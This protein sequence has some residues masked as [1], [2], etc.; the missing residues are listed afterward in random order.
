MALGINTNVASLSAQN[1]LTKSQDMNSQALERL[2]SGLRI[3][4]AKDDAAGLAISTR[5]SSQISGL[6]VAGRNAN[7]AISLAQ[8][9]EGAL[10]EITNN[11]QRIRELAV[12]SANSTNSSSDRDALNQ[13]VQQRVEEVNRIAGQTSFNG[14][15][16]LNG[17][18]GQAE[19]QVGANVGE[20]IGLDLSNSV[21]SSSIG[22][23]AE[24]E[25]VDLGTVFAEA[26][27]ATAGTY[28]TGEI[29]NFDFSDTAAA[30]AVTF[31]DSILDA[32]LAS[33]P[34]T[35]KID[36]GDD[37]TL[38]GGDLAANVAIL[39]G[40]TGYSAAES[41][42]TI[43]LTSDNSAAAPAITGDS[44][45][46]QTP[47]PG[48]VGET[49]F[50]VDGNTVTL[51]TDTS[52]LAG[53]ATEIGTQLGA[54]YAV[55]ASST[56]V[57]I[58]TV[59]TGTA[60]AA[61]VIASAT[62]LDQ[63][64]DA[65]TSVAG[66]AATSPL[67]LTLAADALTFQIG[68]AAAVSVKADTYTSAESL[69]DSVNKALGGDARA[70]LGDDGVLTITSGENITVTGANAEAGTV[71][72]AGETAVTGS[73]N[74]ADVLT[75]SSASDAIQSVDAALSSIS[76]LRSTF[77]AIQNR[78]ESTI[79]NLSTSVE[80]LSAA[81][82]RILDADFAS[83]TANLAKSQVLQQAG[84]S[85]LAQANARPQQVLSLLQ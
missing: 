53:L 14:L 83:E 60:A 64:F 55:T 24:A 67:D 20:T 35:I 26:A 37:I 12:Q 29:T 74:S 31:S 71:F 17:T 7:D 75:E 15:K 61:P 70:V 58:A 18:F 76:D 25:S 19:F 42:G 78:F 46:A 65:G 22:G 82:S 40:Q 81:N 80:N 11:L 52:S 48:T 16:V 27:D 28:T 8:T 13:E 49:A 62:G 36:G 21:R 77:G 79:A 43:T 34:L 32:D 63:E 5:F 59:A 73:L 30:G 33:S 10:S 69:V 39:D 68:D 54:D 51:N 44:V 45:G 3:N 47:V 41:S 56:G 50:E 72:A 38:N 23:V 4:S 84:I 57:E 2:S 66:Q 85:V 1:Q 9:A 6:N